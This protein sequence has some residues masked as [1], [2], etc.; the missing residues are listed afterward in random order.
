MASASAVSA[1]P[2]VTVLFTGLSWCAFRDQLDVFKQQ[3][4]EMQKGYGTIEKSA[5]AAK[6]A[7]EAAQKSANVAERT[8]YV[9]Q[10]PIVAI[11]RFENFAT[12][13]AANNNAVIAWTFLAYIKKHWK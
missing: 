7:A 13:D 3:L 4:G 2:I 8:L 6:D 12:T 9:S 11:E 10:R 1:R 5:D